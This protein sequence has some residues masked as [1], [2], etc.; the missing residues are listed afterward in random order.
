MKRLPRT[1]DILRRIVP[2]LHQ[3]LVRILDRKEKSPRLPATT[4]SPREKEVLKWAKEGKTTWEISE[5]LSIS[6]GTVKF[7][8]RNIFRK[9]HAVTRA[10][11]VAIGVEEHLI[12]L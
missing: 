7:H 1:C 5:I 2:L 6:E 8:T 9:V 11:A 12:D 4:L 3:V 10:Q